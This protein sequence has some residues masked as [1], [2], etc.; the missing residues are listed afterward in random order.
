MLTELVA[1]L[2]I[3]MDNGKGGWD[4]GELQGKG[5]W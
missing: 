4:E 1:E 5:G 3:D 2:F